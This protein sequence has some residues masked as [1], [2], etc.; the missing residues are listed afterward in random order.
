MVNVPTNKGISK[1]PKYYHGAPLIYKQRPTSP[2]SS[3]QQK[4]I[5]SRTNGVRTLQQQANHHY[6]HSVSNPQ[7]IPNRNLPNSN[8]AQ[9]NQPF[10]H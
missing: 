1:D 7:S 6:E 3:I 4:E 2:H 9:D 8:L 5:I 10:L